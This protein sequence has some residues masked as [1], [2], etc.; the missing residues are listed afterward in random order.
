MNVFRSEKV[1]EG[2]VGVNEGFYTF[3]Q[4]SSQKCTERSSSLMK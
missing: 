4:R 1:T 3:Y 2:K